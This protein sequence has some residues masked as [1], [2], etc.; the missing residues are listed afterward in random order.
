MNKE[1]IVS[2]LENNLLNDGNIW[3]L[4]I[5]LQIK[6]KKELSAF[7]NE[8]VVLTSKNGEHIAFLDID[9]I[10][11][12]D[13]NYLCEKWFNTSSSNHP[14]VYQIKSKGNYIVS[15]NVS[16]IKRKES[17]YRIFDLSPQET[18]FIFSQ[19]NWD[20]IVGFH[21]R[22]PIHRA[23]EYIQLSAMEI[24]NADGMFIN[25]VIG[26]KKIGDFL[27]EVVLKVIN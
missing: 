11:E 26:P 16:L 27:P 25:P 18:R 14:G 24:S 22:N 6:D 2:V 3:T 10:E 19:K 17:P 4:P 8:R 23:H 20:V 9:A 15:G 12:I 13:L 7:I 1:N 5:I 21:T